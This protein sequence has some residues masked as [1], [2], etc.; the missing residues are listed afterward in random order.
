MIALFDA[1]DAL[2]ADAFY[3]VLGCFLLAFA[4]CERLA[5]RG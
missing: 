3:A 2:P 5:V 4:A 1:F